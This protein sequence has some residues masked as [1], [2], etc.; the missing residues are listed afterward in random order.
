MCELYSNVNGLFGSKQKRGVGIVLSVFFAHQTPTLG[1]LNAVY[2]GGDNLKWLYLRNISPKR[3]LTSEEEQYMATMMEFGPVFRFPRKISDR[4]VNLMFESGNVRRIAV[5]VKDFA[6]PEAFEL[7]L[8]KR[9]EM[10]KPYARSSRALRPDYAYALSQYLSMCRQPKCQTEK[11]QEKLLE[12]AD[13][14]MLEGLCASQNMSKNL[15]HNSTISALIAKRYSKAL[16]AMLMHS[17]VPTS[18]LQRY[19]YSSFPELKWELEISKVRHA[20]RKLE[21]RYGEFWG[22]EAPNYD[23]YKIIDESI[24]A[25]NQL[26]FVEGKV[27][28]RINADIATPYFC[29]WATDEYPYL[30]ENAYRCIRRF[31]EKYLAASKYRTEC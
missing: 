5:Y 23:E 16:R 3:P 11:V 17:F 12:V 14:D 30:G 21:K 29:A 8:I 28:S 26:D 19:L 22:V 7:E 24:I 4:A 20:L 9:Y 13:E 31:A 15:L 18:E 27:Q 25:E 10:Q 1:Q 6:L 2:E